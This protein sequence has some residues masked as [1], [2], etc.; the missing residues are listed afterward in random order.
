MLRSQLYL[1]SFL[2]LGFV[3]MGFV[4]LSGEGWDW[5]PVMLTAGS[6]Y[7]AILPQTASFNIAKIIEGAKRLGFWI[8][9][10]E[11]LVVTYFKGGELC[12]SCDPLK[13]QEFFKM[14]SLYVDAGLFLV[15]ID[16]PKLFF[17]VRP[18]GGSAA[19]SKGSYEIIVNPKTDVSTKEAEDIIMGK[20]L[21]LGVLERAIP[22]SF[23]L[24]KTQD[25]P[26]PPEG[27]LLDST[28]FALTQA[29]DWQ[30]FA[31]KKNIE[32]WGLRVRVLIE[33]KSP[34]A[35]LQGA[36]N[37]IVLARSASGLLRALVLIPKL[38]EVAKDPAVKFVRLPS[39]PQS[40]KE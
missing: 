40:Q 11:G 35:Q 20:L 3:L 23:E 28:L 14:P 6:Y 21:Q 12:A 7:G 2:I 39:Q 17:N 24:L 26:K 22:L 4:K 38:I 27:L 5:R 31:S 34:D 8:R 13:E 18:L 29:P 9:I 32:L 1:A 37:V 25:K 30:E 19:A 36:H 10:Q 33:L 15:R 16:E